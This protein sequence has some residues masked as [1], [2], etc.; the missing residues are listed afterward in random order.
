MCLSG[1]RRHTTFNFRRVMR[2]IFLLVILWAFPAFADQK[3]SFSD[4]VKDFKAEAVSKGVN[5]QLVDDAF[6][7]MEGPVADIIEQDQKQPEG[8]RTFEEYVYGVVTKDKIKAAKKE[9][10]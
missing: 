10:K 5:A 7:N 3:Q 8:T 1:S 6:S 4:W 2:F 9:W